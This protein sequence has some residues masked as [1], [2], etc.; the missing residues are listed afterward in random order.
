M[1]EINYTF[2]KMIYKWTDSDYVWMFTIDKGYARFEFFRSSIYSI[3]TSLVILFLSKADSLNWLSWASLAIAVWFAFIAANYFTSIAL[4]LKEQQDKWSKETDSKLTLQ[5]F[6]KNGTSER[7]TQMVSFLKRGIVFS[8]FVVIVVVSSFLVNK[9]LKSEP[10]NKGLN[11]NVRSLRETD[12]LN[13]ENA[14]HLSVKIDSL[15]SKLFQINQNID[16]LKSKKCK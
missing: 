5:S 3:T 1:A 11:E 12:S 4:I 7:K 15:N 8:F 16:S 9:F 10:D 14:K 6:T 13:Y 2:W